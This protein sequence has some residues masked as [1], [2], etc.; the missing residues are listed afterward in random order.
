M[1]KKDWLRWLWLLLLLILL[2]FVAYYCTD[3]RQPSGGQQRGG[4]AGP[5][6]NPR[7]IADRSD[8]FS[9]PHPVPTGAR[10][11]ELFGFSLENRL[12]TSSSSSPSDVFVDSISFQATGTPTFPLN[13]IT[14]IRLFSDG[15][16][17][18]GPIQTL[19]LTPATSTIHFQF[20][21]PLGSTK[22]FQLIADIGQ[23]PPGQVQLQLTGMHAVNTTTGDA[24]LV[25]TPDA[26]Y[27]PPPTHY[28]PI[29]YRLYSAVLSVQ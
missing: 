10:N 1:K 17:L 18:A 23:A 4:P 25:Y 27:P 3:Q 5:D 21:S 16:Q 8:G 2:C 24:E 29:Y 6:W 19:A 22:Q 11:I 9:S 12:A 7:L 26:G 13:K 20:V 28:V 14:N 15:T